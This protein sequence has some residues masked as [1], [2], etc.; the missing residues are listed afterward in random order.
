LLLW[1]LLADFYL[2]CYR[3]PRPKLIKL[4]KENV[5]Y[6]DRLVLIFIL[7]TFLLSPSLLAWTNAGGL[8][9]YRP[10]LVWAILITVVFWMSR[11]RDIDGL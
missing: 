1:L 2:A 10:F 11:S 9:W 4:K 3:T 6:I 8:A 7:G 5:M